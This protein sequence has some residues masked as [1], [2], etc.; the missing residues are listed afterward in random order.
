MNYQSRVFI[1]G[2]RA[3]QPT[4]P[5]GPTSTTTVLYVD[6]VPHREKELALTSFGHMRAFNTDNSLSKALRLSAVSQVWGRTGLKTRVI[7]ASLA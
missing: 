2:I 1:L 7:G 3:T 5:A 6:S 4:L